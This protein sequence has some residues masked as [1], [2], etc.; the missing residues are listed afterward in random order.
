V[1][2]FPLVVKNGT[3][4]QLT[5]VSSADGAAAGHRRAGL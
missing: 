4:A 5:N 1:Y 3:K 2:G